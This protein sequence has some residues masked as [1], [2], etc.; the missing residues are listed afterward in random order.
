MGP[1]RGG[2]A[3][4]L[5]LCVEPS[6]GAALR[7]WGCEGGPA[8][9]ER[10]SACWGAERCLTQRRPRSLPEGAGGVALPLFYAGFGLSCTEICV[11]QPCECASPADRGLGLRVGCRGEFHRPKEP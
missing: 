11:L 2:A 3:L 4:G 9:T 7:L 1:R 5:V 8:A 10:R 6:E